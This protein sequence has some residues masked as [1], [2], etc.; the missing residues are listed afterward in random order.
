M[1]GHLEYTYDP[2]DLNVII[3]F[4]IIEIWNSYI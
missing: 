2:I 1:N 4:N 3:F